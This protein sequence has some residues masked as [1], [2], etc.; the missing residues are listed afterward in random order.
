M[1]LDRFRR[2]LELY[3]PGAGKPKR[4][5]Q[6]RARRYCRRLARNHYENFP[7][8]SLLLPRRL[9]PHFFHVYAYCRWAD[10]L[11]DETADPAQALD[12]LDWWQG[13]LDAC[14]QGRAEHPVFVAL[15]PT[16]AEFGIPRRTLAD[17]LVA[18]RQDQRVRSYETLDQ[19]LEYCRYSANPVGRLVLYLGRCFDPRRAELSDAVC[20]GLQL[21]NF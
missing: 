6:A 12:L 11:A 4:L 21:A 14:Y 20:T 3:G 8:A 17:L 16:I 7:V 1:A 9:R 19:L 5:S 2:D 18:F 15:G 13:Q 10:D